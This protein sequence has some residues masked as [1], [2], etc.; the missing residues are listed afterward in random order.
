MDE[1]KDLSMTL[2]GSKGQQ[3]FLQLAANSLSL[4][5]RRCREA[6]HL[7]VLKAIVRSNAN[8]LH[9]LKEPDRNR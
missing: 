7:E 5:G 4:V 9:R 6:Q 3:R 1:R 2:L 8:E